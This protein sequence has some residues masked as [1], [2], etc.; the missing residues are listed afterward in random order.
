M[1][2]R[3]AN[4]L[5]FLWSQESPGRG[6]LDVPTAAKRGR[7]YFLPKNSK[8][9]IITYTSDN[10]CLSV[11]CPAHQKTISTTYVTN[12]GRICSGR[13]QLEVPELCITHHFKNKSFGL[14]A[15]ID[16]ILTP[17]MLANV[18][19]YGIICFGD[20]FDRE[21]RDLR[22]AWNYY[23]ESP[24]NDENSLFYDYHKEH[25][26]GVSKH[27]YAGHD[28]LP[29]CICACCLEIC[30]CP[31]YC[32]MSALF[33]E[34]LRTYRVKKRIDRTNQIQNESFLKM[35]VISPKLLVLPASYAAA[36]QL[37]EFKYPDIFVSVVSETDS[38]FVGQID[39]QP[40]EI[41]KAWINGTIEPP[42]SRDAEPHRTY[43]TNSTNK[44]E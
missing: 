11:I 4:L 39:Q 25:C 38:H 29:N 9:L 13:V 10:V 27:T 12:S 28:A 30:C 1:I 31:C 15:R 14:Y 43:D 19:E 22:Q 41:P 26:A 8:E 2:Q 34:Y 35:D 6:S 21:P 32:V 5:S 23:W 17:Y 42:N 36:L 7:V 20:V 37:K 18:Y 40:V 44:P 33:E 16:G 3:A 24:F